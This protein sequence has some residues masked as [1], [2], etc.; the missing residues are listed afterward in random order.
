MEITNVNV[1]G[2]IYDIKDQTVGDWARSSEKPRYTANEV[3]A[4]TEAR[5]VEL[6]EAQLG[7]IENGTY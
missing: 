7:V 3:G 2:T 6:I 4:T 5:V 1:N